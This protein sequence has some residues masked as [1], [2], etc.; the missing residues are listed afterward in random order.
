MVCLFL[1]TFE[2]FSRLQSNY[3]TDWYHSTQEYILLGVVI[4]SILALIATIVNW[5]FNHSG[6]ITTFEGPL[7]VGILALVL[8][9][10]FYPAE[11]SIYVF[12]F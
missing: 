1:L 4:F 6:R 2:W 5:F 11:S 10:F 7:S 12:N 8:I 3:L 9:F